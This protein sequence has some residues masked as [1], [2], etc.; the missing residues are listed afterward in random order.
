MAAGSSKLVRTLVQNPVV[1]YQDYASAESSL[2]AIGH[3]TAAE[4]GGEKFT[5]N[6]VTGGL[7]RV[8]DASNKTPKV[9]IEQIK[10][11]TPL[12][13]GTTSENLAGPIMFLAGPMA[14]AVVGQKGV[15]AEG[16]CITEV[17]EWLSCQLNSSL[18]L[19]SMLLDTSEVED[20]AT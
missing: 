6:H 5:C 4:L 13:R 15:F 7:L 19:C 11:V 9:V 10:A 17:I 18:S 3:T 8:T 2:L 12:Q 1:S 16:M 14:T 20:D